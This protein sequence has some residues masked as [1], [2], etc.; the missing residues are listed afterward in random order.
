MY[1]TLLTFCT[2]LTVGPALAQEALLKSDQQKSS[3]AIGLTIAQSTARQGVTLDYD[4][5]VLGVRD[6]LDGTQPRLSQ[7]EFAA[8]LKNATHSVNDRFKEQAQANLK[9]GEAFLKENKS[10]EGVIELSSGLQ[11]K[12][13]RKGAGKHPKPTDT[14]VVHYTGTLIDGSEFDSSKRRGQPATLSLDSVIPGWQEAIPL[15][16]AGSR[17]QIFIPPQLAYGAKGSG[18]IGPNETLVFEIEL[19]EIAK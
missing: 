3:Y 16:A 5:F 17:W 11:Y 9:A 15:M 6:G 19:L 4:A 8:A 7:E 18:P 10:K 14:V 13:L 12:E 1:R 2:F